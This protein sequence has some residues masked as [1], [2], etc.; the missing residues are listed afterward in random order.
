MKVEKLVGER[1]KE[2]PSDYK[3]ES[4]ALM[5]RG[6]YIKQV[7]G[8]IFSWYTP[9]RR[10]TRKIE[11]IIREEMEAV[12]GQEVLLPLVVPASLREESEKLSGPVPGMTD[13][14]AAVQLV[15][16]YG[17]SYTRYPFMIFQIQTKFKEEARPRG[18]LIYAREFTIMEAYSFHTSEEDLEQHYE[19]CLEAYKRIF[20][21]AG[22]PQVITVISDPGLMEGN[23]AVKFM[24]LTPAGEDLAAVCSHCGY[25]AGVDVAEC[26][27]KN[28][29]DHISEELK[30]VHTPGV[31]TI[32]D[33][34][35]FLGIPAEKTCKAVVYQKNTDDR[36]VVV[37]VRG[38]LEVSE[39]KIRNFLGEDIRPAVITDDCGLKAGYIGPY[40]LG[41]EFTVLF[42]RS[43]K[44][45]NNLSCGANI[46]EY[47]Y[48]GLDIERDLGKVEYHDFSK[49]ADGC[50]CPV[51]GNASVT[52]SGGIELGEILQLGTKYTGALNMQYLDKDGSSSYPFMDCC[53]IGIERLAAAVCEAHHDEHGPIWPLSIAPWEVH[54][55]C[56]RPDNPEIKEA[57]DKLYEELQKQ[58][59]EV[60][61]DDRNVSAG[62]MFSDA[63]LLGVPIRVIISPRNM[64]DN[65]LEI[66]TR[67]RKISMKVAFDKAIG[68]IKALIDNA[69]C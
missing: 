38:D 69:A 7:S 16:E 17:Q 14:E 44:G 41:S 35:N 10:I 55:C 3:T 57:A 20:A 21:R 40:N 60:I 23:A 50:I 28:E 39:T 68:E 22:L 2:K 1:F 64:K 15:R 19:K 5:L 58:G 66:T 4:H 63:D 32:E 67:D 27:V 6:G 18:G 54:I 33:L 62:V 13:E 47:H 52:I 11:R 56:L 8:G 42:D 51:C 48:T 59:I 37:F 30:P 46:Y 25:S 61:Y 45:A 43:L 29:R 34:C 36:Y 26:I 9:L 53:R 65:C 49:T 24:L 12:G 31:H